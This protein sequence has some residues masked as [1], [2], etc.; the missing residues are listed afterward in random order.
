MSS[1]ALLV[2]AGLIGVGEPLPAAA[3]F[4]TTD[5][6][7]K[8]VVSFPPAPNW[9]RDDTPAQFRQL[10]VARQSIDPDDFHEHLLSVAI[11]QET[12]QRRVDLKLPA[13][14][15][16][17]KASTA[18][19][20]HAE[21]MARAHTLSHDETPGQPSPTAALS[22]LVRQGLRP[23]ATAENIAYNFLLD[24]VPGK[25]F[26]ARREHG[27]NVYSYRPGGPSLRAYT[28]DG[29]ARAIL[30][31]WMRSPLHHAHIVD[32]DL[33][34]LGVGVAL[35]HRPNHPDT[36]YATQDFYTPHST[37]PATNTVPTEATLLPTAR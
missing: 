24:L 29:F 32:P 34:F 25:P 6:T 23:H 15:P 26:Y 19:R 36:I 1:T 33:R 5:A 37:P 11:F 14:L 17:E 4:P 8:S 2:G 13:F 30:S 35:A 21:W 22:R 27:R 20:L 12:N 16:D 7:Q 3:A 10:D 28:Y 31:Q 18:A 9:A